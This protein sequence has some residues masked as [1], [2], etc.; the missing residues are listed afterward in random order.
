MKVPNRV[1][2]LSV[3]TALCAGCA[4]LPK[5]SATERGI[6]WHRHEAAMLKMKEWSLDGQFGLRV[7]HRGWTAGMHWQETG[8]HYRIDIYGPLGRT[9]AVI[10][11]Y[12]GDVVLHSSHGKLYHA[13]TAADLMKQVLGWSL[14]V[15][16][17]RYWVRGI[18]IPDKPVVAQKLDGFGRLS[19]LK[20][21]GWIIRYS[22]YNYNT[23]KA[24]PTRLTMTQG[25]V[26]LNVV[27][28]EWRNTD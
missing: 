8:N 21:S 22:E 4:S 2:I 23:F 10:S 12:P 28:N 13:S 5:Q 19:Y 27:I 20:Q 24:R 9:V 11:G 14:P 25:K 3:L 18:P 26:R 6:A 1:V 16:G 17:M 7:G 15:A